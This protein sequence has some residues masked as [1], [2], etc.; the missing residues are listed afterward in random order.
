MALNA[1][2]ER[3]TADLAT[4]DADLA[5]RDAQLAELTAELEALRNPPTPTDPQTAL[6]AVVQTWLDDTAR[7]FGYDNI[8]SA[9][10]YVGSSIDLWNAQGA[11]FRNWRDQ[12][13]AACIT[14]R[15]DVLGGQ[16]A[17]PAPDELL[18]ELPQPNIP[19]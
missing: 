15:S 7:A 5:A 3:L 10:S 9:V 12:V 8:V 13:W 17:V 6:M 16:R 2:V 19:Q 4:R 11:A 14:V 18:A 1:S